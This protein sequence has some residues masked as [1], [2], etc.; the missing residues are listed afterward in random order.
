VLFDDNGCYTAVRAGRLYKSCCF[1]GGGGQKR[2]SF[3]KKN[4]GRCQNQEAAL[5]NE[6]RN[7]KQ[8][9]ET[10]HSLQNQNGE[11]CEENR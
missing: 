8:E 2:W 5:E 11:P 9:E 10:C 1:G 7:T 6:H 4:S 3:L